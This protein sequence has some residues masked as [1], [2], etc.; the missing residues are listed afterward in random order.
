MKSG[1]W[2]RRWLNLSR[3][4]KS[5]EFEEDDKEDG[6]EDGFCQE[7]HGAFTTLMNIGPK[8][9]GREVKRGISGRGDH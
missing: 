5:E 9:F 6:L 2:Y 1:D 4:D 8:K 7:M 3:P